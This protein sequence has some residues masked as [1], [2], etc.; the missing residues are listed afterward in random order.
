MHSLRITPLDPHVVVSL[1]FFKNSFPETSFAQHTA[2]P[3][4]VCR[5]AGLATTGFEAAADA[6]S[7]QLASAG[8][9]FTVLVAFTLV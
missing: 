2:R 5:S 7:I 4:R 1:I 9:Q 3:F 6:C 8:V